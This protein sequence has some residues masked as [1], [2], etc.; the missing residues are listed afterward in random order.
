MPEVIRKDR[1]GLTASWAKSV[2]PVEIMGMWLPSA[3]ARF[4]NRG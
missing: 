4:G 3:E 1:P 2:E